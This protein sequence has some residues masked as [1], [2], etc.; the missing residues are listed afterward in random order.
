MRPFAGRALLAAL[1]NALTVLFSIGSVGALIPILNLIFET[2]G[3]DLV[4][5]AGWKL[6][7]ATAV[8][9]YKTLN[10]ARATLLLTVLITFGLFVLKN[11]SR[12]AALYTLAPVR[13]GVVANFKRSLHHHWISMPVASRAKYKKGDL[14][15]RA[16]ADL[17]EIE[18]SMLKGMEG[19]V[20]DPLMILGTL[21]I[22]FSMSAKLTVFAV[23]IIPISGLLIAT[24]GKSLKRSAKQA[25]QELGQNTAM[26]EEALA[27]HK[28]IKSFV[29]HGDFTARFEQS[30]AKWA[31]LMNRVFRKRDLSSPIAEILGISVLLSV[32]YLG[33]YVVLEERKLTGGE[34][35]AFVALFYQLIPAFK[36][37]TNAIY[38]IQKGNA[39]A[40][41]VLS[42][43]EEP[44]EQLGGAEVTQSAFEQPIVMDGVVFSYPGA[45]A[46]ALNGLSVHIAP[47]KTT[48]LVGPSG[49][50]KSTALHLLAGFDVAGQGKISLGSTALKDL[51]LHQY[52][53]HLGWVP[54]E[55]MLFNDTV[56]FNISLSLTPDM[57]QVRAAAEAAHCMEF[58][59][60]LPNGMETVIGENGGS[61]SGGQRQR[62]CIARAFYANPRLLILDE[63]TAALDNQSEAEVQLALNELMKG[64][65]TVV[66]AHRLSTVQNADQLVYIAGGSAQECGTHAEL[67]AQDGKY[68]ALAKLGALQD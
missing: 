65:T 60:Q 29:A 63:A 30:V 66:V 58:V 49:G 62:L 5:A 21:G 12:Y 13:N 43:L 37:L 23:A 54:Q 2:P 18:W 4:D 56:A 17:N 26:L 7:L 41:R 67:M 51:N 11:I 48:A 19:L 57:E 24:I 3:V 38:D 40:E 33:G 55:A 20:R 59:N 31:R 16:T 52:R 32:L 44:E 15:T 1:F 34:L 28:V 39:S 10:G 53:N 64:R 6:H 36:N 47:G 8:E 46:P 27:N 22:L 42:I 45:E 9:E 25:Q 50:G 61:L 14:L 68:A 35:V